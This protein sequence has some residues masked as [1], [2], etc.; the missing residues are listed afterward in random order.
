MIT[1][2]VV[3]ISGL[4]DLGTPPARP[5]RRGLALRAEHLQEVCVGLAL[6][7]FPV[8]GEQASVVAEEQ[9]SSIWRR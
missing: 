8:E 3:V 6:E 1:M 7:A 9:G 5:R 2:S 4:A